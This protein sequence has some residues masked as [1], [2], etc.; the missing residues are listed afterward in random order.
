[1]PKNRLAAE[2]SPYLHQHCDNP[3]NWYPWGR[4]ALER[5]K[6]EDKPV[7]LSIGYSAC[8][9]CHVM[10]HESFEDE[11]T[12]RFLNERFVSVKVD[13]EERPDLDALYMRAVI[14]MTGAGG[15]PLTVFLS[16]SLKP[17]FG[18]TYFPKDARWGMPSFRQVLEEVARAY[19]TRR[20]ELEGASERLLL[21]LGDSFVRP[22]PAVVEGPALARAA[23]EAIL[24]RFDESH[25]GFGSG[26]KFPQ[27]PLL[28]FLLDH[29]A[30]H[31]DEALRD[32]VLFT[33]RKMEAGGIRDQVGGGFHR[34]SVDGQW[35]VPHYEKMLYDNAQLASL[36]FRASTVPGGEGL[37]ET[38]RE[39]LADIAAS[40]AAPG[41]GFH[42]SLDADSEG[43][44][45]RYYLWTR[46]Q[47]KGL[48]GEEEGADLASL[49]GIGGGG[50]LEER[51]L[52]QVKGWR[53]AAREAGL[54]EGPYQARVRAALARL[55][56]A[57]ADRVPPGRDTKVLTDWNAL[58]ASA[59]LDG[60]AATGDAGLLEEGERTLDFA[61]R[62]CWDGSTLCH[63]WDGREAKVPGFLADYACLARAEWRAFEVT[64]IPEHLDRVGLLLGRIRLLFE[65]R[66]SGS[67]W[68]APATADGPLVPIRDSEDG[69]LPSASAVYARLLWNWSR[70]TGSQESAGA[71]QRHMRAESGAV[72]A[73]PGALPLLA[74]LFELRSLPPEEVVIAAPNE[75]AARPWFRAARYGTRPGLLVLPLLADRWSREEA[76][77]YALFAGRW[78]ARQARAYLCVGGTCKAPFTSPEELG[79]ALIERSGAKRRGGG[80]R[81]R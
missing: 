24:A 29:A 25:G 68:D 7:F 37:A 55:R 14:L 1:V 20:Q 33:L 8:H 45:G 71:L 43:E 23:R 42:A 63:V 9:W 57:R 48:L 6:R 69:V 38:G 34:Y 16:P 18:G 75:E 64:G 2:T 19:A 11:A 32:R 59:F 30:L 5:A 41:G 39:I 70:L 47:L 46:S 49:F 51:T 3:V 60:F 15:W 31:G 65:D 44:E 36:Y 52:H 66:E 73:S 72:S 50:G 28:D 35:T 10:A 22:E 54:E 4:E 12:A 58:A 76:E 61:W 13:R 81:S 62:R 27:P 77:N 17:F 67:L 79:E 40:L 78:E 21:A 56:Q 80:L 53:E 26:P 74:G